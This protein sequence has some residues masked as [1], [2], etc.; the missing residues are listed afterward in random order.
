MNKIREIIRMDELG[1][2]QRQ[3]TWA[4]NVSRPVIAQYLQD[5]KN[6]GLHYSD[7]KDVSEDKLA[8]IFFKKKEKSERYQVLSDQ[9]TLIKEL[10]RTG[11]TLYLLWEEYRREHPDGYSYSQFCY[12]FQIWRN[13]SPLTMH[14]EDKA[15]DKMFVDFTGKHMVL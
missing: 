13:L 14:I 2:A 3:I 12:H 15:G 5:F 6:T 4:L 9:F 8:A 7:I 10:K 11:V 1:F